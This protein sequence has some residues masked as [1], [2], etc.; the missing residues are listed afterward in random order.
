MKIAAQLTSTTSETKLKPA[1]TDNGSPGFT[2][3]M[4]SAGTS[5]VPLVPKPQKG[6]KSQDVEGRKQAASSAVKLVEVPQ[7]QPNV[8]PAEMQPIPAAGPVPAPITDVSKQAGDDAP[9]LV[10]AT[11]SIPVQ[12][13][14]PAVTS[15]LGQS[16]D[17][18]LAGTQTQEM[19]AHA[20]GVVSSVSEALSTKSIGTTNDPT[21]SV[22]EQPRPNLATAVPLPLASTPTLAKGTGDGIAEHVVA[23]KTISSDASGVSA[24]LPS[25]TG[26]QDPNLLAQSISA[27]VPPPIS[28]EVFQVSTPAVVQT[29]N[30]GG[31]TVSGI[32]RTLASRPGGS[33]LKT[34][35]ASLPSEPHGKAEDDDGSHGLAGGSSNLGTDFSKVLPTPGTALHSADNSQH[36]V[37][38]SLLQH[39]VLPE[40]LGQTHG[41]SEDAQTAG[42][43]PQLIAPAGTMHASSES[44]PMQGVTGAQLT[45]TVRSSEMKLG[46]QSAE[47]GNISISTSLNRQVIS[48]QISIDHSELG[49]AIAV[50]LPAMEEKLGAAYGVQA[51]VELR[52]SNA[53]SLSNQSSFS[54][55]GQQAQEDR[56][57][58]RS[59][60]TSGLSFDARQM[61]SR[62]NVAANAVAAGG[63]RL[64]IR[65]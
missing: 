26:G 35:L 34:K 11:A 3:A 50:H 43:L 54:Q 4:K 42:I 17:A 23:E 24:S 2:D 9:S 15:A 13:P 53:A 64:D 45:Q 6:S 63:S 65:I 51:R 59:A 52:D 12:A 1:S 58:G 22:A 60:S 41:N 18:P 29:T 62:P 28:T 36:A 27:S 31:S 5:S 46:M 30:P 61:V 56:Q 57:S 40:P 33:D 37:D 39:D 8:V 7:S 44:L 38:T 16:N 20:T 47:F 10:N 49:R 25:G 14:S 55:P 21:R 19:D 32:A 48:A